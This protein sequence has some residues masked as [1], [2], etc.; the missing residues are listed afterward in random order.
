MAAF[1][2]TDTSLLLRPER[3]GPQHILP[4]D[5][6]LKTPHA[7]SATRTLEE[8]DQLPFTVWTVTAD[9][10]LRF[11]F[12]TLGDVLRAAPGI[13]VSQPGNAVEGEMFLMRGLAGNQHVKVLINDVPI[14]SNA[15]HGVTIGAQLPIR[16]AERIEVVY[17]PDGV[18]YGGEACAGVVNIILRET[19]RPVF[20]QADLSFGSGGFNNL[21]LMFG[22]KMGRDRNI[23]RFSLYGSSTVRE[24]WDVYGD[25]YRTHNPSQYHILDI[26]SQEYYEN[27]NFEPL[28]PNVNNPKLAP[29]AH[30]SRLFGGNFTWRG[31]HFTYQRMNRIDHSALGRNLMSVSWSNPGNRLSE[32]WETLSIGHRNRKQSFLNTFSLSRYRVDNNS[33]NTYLFNNLFLAEYKTRFDSTQPEPQRKAI[34]DEIF[35]KYASGERYASANALDLRLESRVRA[36]FSTRLY[37][38]FGLQLSS[39]LGSGITAYYTAPVEERHFTD[40]VEAEPFNVPNL[41]AADL[42]G[43]LFTQWAWRGKKLRLLAGTSAYA[44]LEQGQGHFP[45]RLAGGYR[46]DSSWAL[47]ANYG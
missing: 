14:T 36:A 2:Q 5:F 17:G 43:N 38:D 32:R 7:L 18:L 12:V 21:D 4:R 25:Q 23:F 45:L 8:V 40:Y 16:Q 41:S 31:F 24:R 13:R 9:D 1:A 44:S 11:G 3:L 37:W 42:R 19:E 35:N 46:I 20:M 26:R 39:S 10:I 30:E 22:G 33:S 28:A 27:P 34:R 29:I 15:A 47:Y 6:I